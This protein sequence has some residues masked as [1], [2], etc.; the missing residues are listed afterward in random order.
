[1]APH[2]TTIDQTQVD[3]KMH[4]EAHKLE[5]SRAPAVSQPEGGAPPT[6]GPNR[7]PKAVSPV[8]EMDITDQDWKYFQGKWERYKA[9]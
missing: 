9:Y 5:A 3:L 2:L 1:M 4:I 7:T 6:A 8:V